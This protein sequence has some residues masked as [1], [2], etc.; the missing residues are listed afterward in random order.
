MY[1]LKIFNGN[2][3]LEQ[4]ECNGFANL[5]VL[6]DMANKAYLGRR[7]EIWR[8]GTVLVDKGRLDFPRD[9]HGDSTQKH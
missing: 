5:K 7:Y 8:D 3:L 4:Q 1:A 9:V 2:E 6:I